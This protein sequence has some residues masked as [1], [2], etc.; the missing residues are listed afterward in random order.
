MRHSSDTTSLRR[1]GPA[2]A[3]ACALVLSLAA[4]TGSTWAAP[5]FELTARQ[6]Q[7]SLN[8][9]SNG[10][11]IATA[12]INA[13]TLTSS[14]LTPAALELRE[15]TGQFASDA[16]FLFY[17]DLRARWD[18]GQTFETTQADGG[19]LLQAAS[20]FEL[21]TFGRAGLGDNIDNCDCFTTVDHPYESL[22]TLVLSFSLSEAAP[23]SADGR[24][25]KGQITTLQFSPDGGT[26]WANYSGWNSFLTFGGTPL[27]GP[28]ETR[29]WNQS[30]T[31]AAG[32]YRMA[33]SP[34]G[35]GNVTYSNYEWSVNLRIAGAE[36]V[37]AVPEPG[38]AT[39][40]GLGLLALLGA[41][42]LRRRLQDRG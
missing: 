14:S 19:V 15:E 7:V 40:A 26:T 29:V 21:D 9:I 12:R 27:I 32:L 20:R 11:G 36:L 23:F 1:H 4:A 16:Q 3:A 28:Q 30:G 25:A 10:F 2:R 17:A 35:Y 18:I 33:N 22:N 38:A 5:Q 37:T 34:D 24:S 31:L 42:G 6:S 39:L 8:N 13:G 41:P